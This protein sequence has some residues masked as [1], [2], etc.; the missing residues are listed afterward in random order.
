LLVIVA[1]LLL[2]GAWTTL[3]L[4]ARRNADEAIPLAPPPDARP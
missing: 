3:I 2:I 4:F 1:F